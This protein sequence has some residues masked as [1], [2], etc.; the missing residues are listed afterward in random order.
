MGPL[1]SYKYGL[2][3][4]RVFPKLRGLFQIYEP[5][6]NEDPMAN[7]RDADSLGQGQDN[8]VKPGAAFGKADASVSFWR[9]FSPTDWLAAAVTFLLAVGFFAYTLA[10]TVTLEDSGERVVAA[11][12]SELHAQQPGRI[13]TRERGL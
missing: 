9:F 11:G 12:V 5:L 10:P 8:T 3:C 7:N 1:S 13:W 4:L 6:D 2:I